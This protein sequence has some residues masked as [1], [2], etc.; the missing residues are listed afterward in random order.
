MKKRRALLLLP[1]LFLCACAARPR[2]AIIWTDRPEIAVYAEYFNADHDEKVEVRYFENPVQRLTDLRK[3]TRGGAGPAPEEERGPDILVAS[4]LKSASSRTL[5]RPLQSYFREGSLRA[6]QFYRRLLSLG[7]IEEKQYLLPVSFNIPAVAF[8]RENAGLLSGPFTIG[9]EEIRTLGK[10]YNTYSAVTGNGGSY[11]RMGFSPSWNSEFL[12][13]TATLFNTAFREAETLTWNGDALEEAIL[14]VRRWIE[15]ANTDIASEDDFSFKY[16]F[17]P[18]VKLVQSGRILFTCL[19][20]A[21]FFVMSEELRDTL[22]F[23]WL[24]GSRKENGGNSIPLEENS[25]WYG[26][27][28]G[29]KAGAAT[30]AFTRWL[31]NSETQRFLLEESR[32]L[33]MNENTFGIAQGFS[34]L[35]SVTEQ[36]FPQFYP[37]LLGHIPPEESLE[38]PDILPRNWLALKRRVILPYLR[39]QVRS[40][41]PPQSRVLEQQITNWMRLNQE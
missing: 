16:F 13:L 4:W 39:E 38:P 29:G 21:E 27:C 8:A 31:F 12:F 3:N 40:A 41:A 6:D 23:R 25:T 1:F 11:T 35:R 36:I 26:V 5:F 22:D 37:G 19:G 14:Y 33:R 32:R 24:S 9:L 30:E 34:A 7:R 20:S 2:A 28:R 17:V 18:P 15:D 10:T